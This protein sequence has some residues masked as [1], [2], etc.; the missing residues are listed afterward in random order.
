[1]SLLFWGLGLLRASQK[2]LI[3]G[4]VAFAL[5]SILLICT[6]PGSASISM[7]GVGSI[8]F[9][10]ETLFVGLFASSS[11]PLQTSS[12]LAIGLLLIALGLLFLLIV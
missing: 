8:L 3:V 6:N 5:T 11:C 1:M 2:N 4:C 9:G 12:R 7:L 10:A